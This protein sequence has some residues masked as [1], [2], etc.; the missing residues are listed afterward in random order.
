M[1][2]VNDFLYGSYYKGYR[3]ECN[4]TT[5]TFEVSWFHSG[6]YAHAQVRLR[7]FFFDVVVTKPDVKPD[8][9]RFIE[10]SERVSLQ[11]RSYGLDTF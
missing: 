3:S 11:W 10:F 8:R 1:T 4:A 9:R 7:F 5:A 6:E 2:G